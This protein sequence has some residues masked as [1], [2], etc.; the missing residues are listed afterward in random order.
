MHLKHVDEF[1][2]AY[3]PEGAWASLFGRS[4]GYEGT[5]LFRDCNDENVYVTLDSWSD[6]SAWNLFLRRWETEYHRL[7][8]ALGYLTVEDHDL[9]REPT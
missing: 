3:G 7:D 5:R 2:R 8:E 1:E 6:E 9:L 4:P